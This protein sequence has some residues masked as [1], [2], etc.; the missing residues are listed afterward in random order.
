MARALPLLVALL[1]AAGC[2]PDLGPQP[3]AV[4]SWPI[5]YGQDDRLEVYEADEPFRGLAQQSA[6]ALLGAPA[7][8]EREDGSYDV[9]AP[10][11][12]ESFSLCEGERFP[13]QTAAATCSGVLI[14]DDLVATAGH[15]LGSGRGASSTGACEEQQRALDRL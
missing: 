4:A 5:V 7:L 15:C 2:D 11:L 12:G 1:C 10:P 3:A 13:E 8:R 6:V 14:G 9:V